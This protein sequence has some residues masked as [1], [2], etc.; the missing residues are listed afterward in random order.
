MN[1]PKLGRPCLP[2]EDRR[3]CRRSVYVTEATEARFRRLWRQSG[4]PSQS[5]FL[6][7]VLE[8]GAEVFEAQHQAGAD[9]LRAK[10]RP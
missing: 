3:E 6:A 5:A 4:F 1:E 8:L 9:I 10:T 7:H 2:A